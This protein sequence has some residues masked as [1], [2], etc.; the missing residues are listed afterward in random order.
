[1]SELKSSGVPQTRFL[2]T[3]STLFASILIL[4]NVASSAK[5]VDLGFSLGSLKFVFDGGTILFPLSYVFGD[6]FSEVY[7]F[8]ASRKVIWTGFACLALSSLFFMLLYVLPGDAEWEGYA[9]QAAYAAILGGMS[10]GGLALASLAG[11]LVGE[12][13]NS[14]TLIKI[15]SLMRGRLLFVRTITSTLIGEFLDSIVFVSIATAFGVFGKD[16][17][18]SL[19]LTNYIFKCLI[20]V[21]MTPVTYLACSKLKKAESATQSVPSGE[22]VS[23]T[24]SAKC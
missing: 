9:G 3:I 12:F 2:G 5:I 11:Y 18:W 6:I 19:V 10:S 8:K 1:M 20:E 24:V 14:V 7:G 16:L 15:K 23:R 22:V 4:S 13:S 21:L 17:F